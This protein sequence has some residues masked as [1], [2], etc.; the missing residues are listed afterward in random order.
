MRKNKP[1]I[2][3]RKVALNIITL[4]AKPGMEKVLPAGI[5]EA[6]AQIL[7]ASGAVSTT[8]VRL[9]HWPGIVSVYEAFNWMMPGQFEAFA[10]R[11]AF[12]ERQVREGIGAGATQVLILGAGYDTLG[13]R[14]APEF[15]GVN[16]FEIDHPATASLKAKGIEKLGPRDNLFL[17]AADLGQRKL[18]DVLA[19]DKTWDRAGQTVIIAEG[20]LMYLTPAAA[21]ELFSQCAVISGKG[22]RIAFTYIKTGPDG[23]PDSGRWTG[24]VLWLLKAT[25]EPWLWSIRPQE[26]GHFL[27]ET[28][29]ENVSDSLG[30]ANKIGVE[31]LG[32]AR[33]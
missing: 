14:L 33:K 15:A 30:T 26:L 3:A 23:R 25:G 20:L 9:A 8:T 31:F 16:F 19:A 5:V 17:I 28:G 27:K 4:G 29:W 24:L 10:H 18:V 32:V 13:W 11:K 2:T 21:R 7:I 1:S 6:T 12:C 22:S